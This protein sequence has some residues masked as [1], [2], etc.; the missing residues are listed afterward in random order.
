MADMTFTSRTMSNAKDHLDTSWLTYHEGHAI[1]KLSVS[2]RSLPDGE[3]DKLLS[4][5]SMM[6]FIF[7]RPCIIAYELLICDQWDV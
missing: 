5:T 4:L 2:S 6:N 3:K 7:I 1:Q